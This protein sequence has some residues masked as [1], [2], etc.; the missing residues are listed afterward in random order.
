MSSRLRDLL[1]VALAGAV[2]FL[3]ALGSRD[4]W[5]PDEA[6]YAQVAR[7]MR[8]SGQYVVPH[9]NGELYMQKPPLLFW[10][11]AA[12]S[13]P[14]GRVT[15]ISARLP[16]AVAAIL[17]LLVVF[18][19]AERLFGRRAAWLAAAAFGTCHKVL[20][21]GR[22]GQIDMLL[23]MLVAVAV[24]FWVRAETE[25]RPALG[26]LF[27]LFAGL[28]TLAKGPVGLLPPLLAI[29]AWTA[30]ERDR[31]ALRRLK[32]GRGLL[33]WAGVVLAW[34]APAAAI[35]GREYLETMVLRQNLTRYADPWHHH[36]P[37]YYY[38]TVLP[39]D[40][41]PWIFLLPA[42]LVAGWPLLRRGRGWRAAGHGPA[43][44]AAGAADDEAGWG[45]PA[46]RARRGLRFALCWVVV[47]LVFFSLSPG[48]RTVYIL[49]M[50]PGLALLVGAGLDRLAARWRGAA[51]SG[52][53]A[54][55][56][57]A[58]AAAPS[59]APR[60]AWLLVPLGL[61]ALLLLGILVA[62]P[63]EG[64]KRPELEVLGTAFLWSLEAGVA[65]LAA[66]VLAAFLC[67]FRRRVVA[68]TG[69]LAA[70]MAALLLVGAFL[71]FPPFDAYKSARPLS[72]ELV[73]RTAP[74]EPYGIY[75]R[76]D[77]T[78]LFY[79]G[80][81]AESLDSEQELRAFVARPGR[82]WVLAERDDLAKLD[83][84]LALVEVARDADPKDGYLLLTERPEPRAQR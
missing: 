73:A 59:R 52:G 16:S 33:L 4:L 79:T 61:L 39:A 6:R 80:R 38:L 54:G 29:L 48:K 45:D 60:R 67:A 77:N 62:L 24:W 13:A 36:Q 11:I 44:E 2:L 21:Q 8:E 7:E 23:T 71:L 34:L 31:P 1:W 64:A 46:E 17:A 66:G 82:A 32:V 12:A 28:A 55:A 56:G 37:W 35:A 50:Y 76:L 19:L 41:F 74:G 3:P 47:T 83:E 27:F 68:M 40:F 53:E 70:G 75:P 20:W 30:W 10:S 57:G 15:E 42:A 9:L 5:N 18:R 78:F 81:F 25:E 63:L 14:W 65:L 22:F 43:A 72:A 49:T 51:P 58:V 69:S 84:P 26:W